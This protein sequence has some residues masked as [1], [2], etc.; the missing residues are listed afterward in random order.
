MHV[1]VDEPRSNASAAHV[2]DLI[3]AARV[4]VLADLGDD[5]AL[6]AHVEQSVQ[7]LHRIHETAA[8]HEHVTEKRVPGRR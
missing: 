1:H 7:A 8:A 5:A 6:Y 4:E 3:I 2:Y